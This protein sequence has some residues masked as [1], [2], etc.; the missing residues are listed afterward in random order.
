MS[1][2]RP[3]HPFAVFE[4]VG[5]RSMRATH[6]IVRIV[7]R[8]LSRRVNWCGKS[9]RPGGPK[10][11][12]PARKRWVAIPN[13]QSPG[14]AALVRSMGRARVHSCHHERVL[15]KQASAVSS[16]ADLSG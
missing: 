9:I 13:D 2:Q 3:P 5:A 4:G 1:L 7:R 10:F 16:E 15:K 11:V 14:G 12:S 8:F 6:L